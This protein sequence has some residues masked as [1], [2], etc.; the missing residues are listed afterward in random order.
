MSDSDLI[1]GIKQGIKKLV[2]VL[3]IEEVS[4]HHS[5]EYAPKKEGY[6]RPTRPIRIGYESEPLRAIY[7]RKRFTPVRPLELEDWRKDK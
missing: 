6:T 2:E 3:H 7:H 5:I 1:W 4:E